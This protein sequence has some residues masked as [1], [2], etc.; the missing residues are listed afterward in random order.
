MVA[1][2]MLPSLSKATW[3]GGVMGEGRGEKGGEGERKGRW[4]KEHKDSVLS[5]D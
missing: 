4:E 1:M 2:G 3:E 5:H